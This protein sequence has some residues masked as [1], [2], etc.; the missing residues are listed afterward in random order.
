MPSAEDMAAAT[1][2]MHKLPPPMDPASSDEG[3][4]SDDS[5]EGEGPVLPANTTA[6]YE[7]LGVEKTAG[8]NEIKKAFH[9]RALKAH[10]DKGGDAAEF[11][12]LQEAYDVLKDEGKRAMYDEYGHKKFDVDEFNQAAKAKRKA[13][14]NGGGGGGGAA[15]A[16]AAQRRRAS[17]WSSMRGG[18]SAAAAAQEASRAEAKRAAGGREEWMLV[19]PAD[20]G[21]LSGL[22]RKAT[23]ARGFQQMAPHTSQWAN[24]GEDDDEEREAPNPELEAKLKEHREARGASLFDQHQKGLAGKKPKLGRA[25]VGGFS[26]VRGGG[27]VVLCTSP[28]PTPPPPS[29]PRRSDGRDA[30]NGHGGD[31]ENRVGC[32]VA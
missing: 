21:L 30:Q 26:W 10:P 3:D 20:D 8:T 23:E 12:K 28:S 29:G 22:K 14:E 4:A 15:D 18:M 1:A 5:Y 27:E 25:P 16:A 7:L 2:A 24:Q 32:A 13:A 17:E 6:F 19:P 9:K 31:V 11:K